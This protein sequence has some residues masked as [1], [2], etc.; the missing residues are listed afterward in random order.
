VVA[1]TVFAGLAAVDVWLVQEHLR[2]HQE[3]GSQLARE[4]LLTTDRGIPE[5]VGYAKLGVA[6]L[7]LALV[8]FLRRRWV[9]GV[10]AA[11][12]LLALVDDSMRVHETAGRWLAERWHLTEGV[13][14]LSAQDVGE[15]AVWGLLGVVPLLV[16]VVL[17][18]RSDPRTR[19]AGTAVAAV[20]GLYAF[21]GIVMDQV[22]QLGA[23][24]PYA[25]L[26]TVVEDGG[27]L[28]ALSLAVALG[29]A[30]LLRSGTSG[31][32]PAHHTRRNEAPVAWSSPT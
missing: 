29:V 20:V 14:G 9:F 21:C 8:A 19:R 13:L 1:V 23:S 27:E 3:E 32:A 22:H 4:W 17:H 15:L 28:I 26:L 10:W 5:R 12:L 16:A 25:Q 31:Q 2:I 6:G 7:L 11:V 30:L 24:G 18:R